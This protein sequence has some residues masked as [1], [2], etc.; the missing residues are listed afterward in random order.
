MPSVGRKKKKVKV[1]LTRR[2]GAGRK[3]KYGED[4]AI[5]SARVP[6]SKEKELLKVVED[7]KREN[8]K[9]VKP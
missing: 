6:K 7:W 1:K 3:K 5:V 2:A 8:V 4:T 9:E